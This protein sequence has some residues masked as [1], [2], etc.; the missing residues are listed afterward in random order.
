M[1]AHIAIEG[2]I[3][4]GKSTLV[5]SLSKILRE[6]EIKCKV[7]Q[8]PVH[9]W[10]CYGQ[11]RDNL[12]EKMYSDPKQWAFKFQLAALVTKCN[13]LTLNRNINILTERCIG[14]QSNVFIPILYEDDNLTNLEKTILEDYI[15][16]LEKNVEECTPNVMI[17]I[18]VSPEKALDR[19]KQRGRQEEEKITIE[20]LER[21]EEK[22]E[23]WMSN[24]T[25]IIK[26]DG[27]DPDNLDPNF[28][29]QLIRNKLENPKH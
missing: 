26:L 2:T 12:L 16:F 14:A 1:S 5:D 4:A 19:I 18:K 21:L 6:K 8:E 13:G 24:T 27:N 9:Q 15:N 3:G 11:N 17:Y 28:V 29:Y 25:D 10:M 22:Y 23:S 7:I 20:Y